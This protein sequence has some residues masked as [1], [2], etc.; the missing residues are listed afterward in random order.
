MKVKCCSNLVEN[1]ESIKKIN[2]EINVHSEYIVYAMYYSIEDIY[3]YICPEGFEDSPRPY[4]SKHFEIIDNKT[5]SY[6]KLFFYNNEIILSFKEFFGKEAFFEKL[7]DGC[8]DEYLIFK[9]Y[10][11][12]MDE[13]FDDLRMKFLYSEDNEDKISFVFENQFGIIKGN[14]QFINLVSNKWYSIELMFN[15]LLEVETHLFFS[16][17]N[18][19]YSHVESDRLILNLKLIEIEEININDEFKI[20][21]IFIFGSAKIKIPILPVLLSYKIGNFITIKVPNKNIEFNVLDE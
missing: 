7:F 5:S 16:Y 17:E 10:K 11:K 14:S 3:Y 21:L 4:S 20:N 8:E 13:E 9:K 6:W 15:I 12:L 2:N 1:K 18:N 19:F